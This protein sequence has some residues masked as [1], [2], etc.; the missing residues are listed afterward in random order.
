M[1]GVAV[2]GAGWAGLAAAV[3]LVRDG[4]QVEVYE[5]APRAGGRARALRLRLGNAE[6]DL[7]NGQHLLIG[8]YRECERLA[9]LV[10]DG[11]APAPLVRHRLLLQSVDGLRM[12]AGALPAPLHLVPAV[13]GARGLGFGERLAIV[14]MMATLRLAGWRVRA[15]ETVQQ[16]LDRLGQPESL[17]RRLWGP[18][19]LGAL[20]TGVEQACAATFA[21]VLRDSLGADSGA[22]DFLLPRG[23]L[24]EVFPDPAQAW[25][26]AAGAAV[27]LRTTVRSLARTPEG[28]RVRTSDREHDHRQVV[29]AVSAPVAAEL[30]DPVAHDDS[31]RASV[32][33]LQGFRHES[34][35]TVYL[36]WPADAIG[37]LPGWIMLEERPGSAAFGQWL[38][39]RGVQQGLR[40]AAVVISARGRAS[41]LDVD[42][43]G[44]GVVRQVAEQLRLPPPVDWRTIV[45][46]R[47]TFL[48]LPDRPRPDPAA[49]G[50]LW[51]AGDHAWPDYPATLEG[52]VRSG[53][54]AAHAL[55]R[56]PGP[57]GPG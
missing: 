33:A 38:F 31:E 21:T 56:G 54:A 1:P 4:H 55:S 20:N 29:L 11:S 13:F 23:T 42:A 25:L 5:A 48:C 2:V 16:L 57:S 7:D 26:E 52:A 18:L 47:A 44:R 3:E 35:A 30:L 8:A 53:V 39:D 34:I 10:A 24:S 14:R 22:A 46:K 6:V 51:L 50:S 32:A 17:Q 9:R 49:F 36:A 45:D 41:R 27:H 43:L 37:A 19:A 28:W 15:G 40:L 12:R